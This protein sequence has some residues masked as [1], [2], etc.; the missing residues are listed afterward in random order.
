MPRAAR[1]CTTEKLG[2]FARD[3]G[4]M[5]QLSRI[6]RAAA[7]PHAHHHEALLA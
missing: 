4:D 5:P 2:A 7:A 3:G 1:N 6:A